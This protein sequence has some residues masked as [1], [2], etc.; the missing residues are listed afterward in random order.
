MPAKEIDIWSVKQSG[1][2]WYE[3]LTDS[4]KTNG[5]EPKSYDPCAYI[6]VEASQENDVV[7]VFWVDDIII[8][9]TSTKDID[10]TRLLIQSKLEMDDRGQP[11]CFHGI[12]FKRLD[13]RHQIN[14]TC[15]AEQI[16]KHHGM[17]DCKP[18]LTPSACGSQLQNATGAE[19]KQVRHSNFHYREVVGSL[20]YLITAT[21]P[22]KSWTKSKLS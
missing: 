2:M 1:R 16:I 9:G 20:I 8:A 3:T 22:D 14:Q 21:R 6:H 17:T 12:D 4:L 15:Y 19:H 18:V 7:L 10:A 5:Y 13:D 11:Q